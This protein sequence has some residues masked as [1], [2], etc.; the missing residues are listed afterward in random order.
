MDDPRPLISVIIPVYNAEAYLSALIDSVLAQTYDHLEVLLVDDGSTDSSAEI[1]DRFAALDARCIVFRKTNGGASSARNTGLDHAK[2]RYILFVDSDDH[3]PRG[4]AEALLS[5]MT[6]DHADYTAGS[7]RTEKCIISNPGL[8]IDF[9]KDPYAL[10]R[11]LT[12]RGSYSPYAKLYDNDIIQKYSIRYDEDLKCAEDALFIRQYLLHCRR[13]SL[14]PDCV[15]DYNT[16]NAGSLSKKTYP[17]YGSY[18]L[19]KLEA[20]KKLV[21]VL[22]L[23]QEDKDRFMKERAIHGLRISTMHLMA[24]GS[25][26]R[27]A[28]IERCLKLFQPY[29]TDSIEP[30]DRQLASWW[31]KHSRQ[32]LNGDTVGYYRSMKR[33][34]YTPK[35]FVKKWLRGRN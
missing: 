27:E 7:I 24:G 22:P 6:R 26:Q 31:K 29:L 32:V 17:D 21:D 1:C 18:F 13:I 23:A 35:A 3:L 12:M 15:Y 5:A 16:G 33:E 9:Q 25:S 11:Y 8:V 34:Y 28:W 10:L 14:I 2:G 4:A 19:K 30:E 20:L